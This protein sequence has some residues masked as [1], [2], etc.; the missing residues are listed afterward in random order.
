MSRVRPEPRVLHSKI[1]LSLVT[2]HTLTSLT[3][4]SELTLVMRGGPQCSAAALPSAQQQH[5][6]PSARASLVQLQANP[7]KDTQQMPNMSYR[8]SVSSIELAAAPLCRAQPWQ[9]HIRGMPSERP[10][11][12]DPNPVKHPMLHVCDGRHLVQHAQ[13]DA[14][15]CLQLLPGAWPLEPVSLE[16][17]V[18]LCLSLWLQLQLGVQICLHGC[19]SSSQA[20][21]AATLHARQCTWAAWPA[22]NVSFSPGFR[23]ACHQHA[24]TSAKK[25]GLLVYSGFSPGFRSACHQHAWVSAKEPAP[26]PSHG[27]AG[28]RVPALSSMDSSLPSM[29]GRQAA[30]PHQA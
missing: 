11:S 21:Q 22:C 23:S 15:H 6:H 25:P 7:M 1:H 24:W 8:C 2:A 20:V 30:L 5:A 9:P 19:E 4:A 27:V 29:P 3:A 13:Q 10:P 12:A 17:L 16:L 26:H 28:V 18:V 14:V